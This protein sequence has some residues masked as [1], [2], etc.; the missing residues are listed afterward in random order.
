MIDLANAFGRVKAEAEGPILCGLL[1]T[2]RPIHLQTQVGQPE[3]V[4]YLWT[5]R[6]LEFL[7]LVKYAAPRGKDS[8]L[9]QN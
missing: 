8:Q 2:R 1:S 3:L 6:Q 7:I 4:Y 5:S 9:N